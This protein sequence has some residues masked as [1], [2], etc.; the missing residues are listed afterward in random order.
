M[1]LLGKLC[2]APAVSGFEDNAQDIAFAELATCTD[3]IWRDRLGNVISCKRARKPVEVAGR[4]RTPKL[5][6]AAHIDEIGLMVSHIDDGGFIRFKPIG[7]FDP[8]TLVS[9]RVHV[10]GSKA[11]SNTLKGVIA[12]QSG[13]LLTAA[14]RQ[15]IF[16][17]RELYIDTGLP[18]KEVL[19]K[20]H[21]GDVITLA[22]T[23]DN[24]NESVVVGRNFDDRVG[25][26]SM[27]EALKRIEHPP[28]DVYAVSTVQEEVGVRGMPTAA[29][30]IAAD[31]GVAIDG[32][33][34]SDTPYALDHERQCHLGGGTGIYLIDNRTIGNPRL[35]RALMET[36]EQEGIAYQRNIGGGTDASVI[37]RSGLG[38]L[39]TTIGA[40]TRYMHSTVQLCH[41]DDIEATIQ[42]LSAFSYRADKLLPADWR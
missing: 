30:A 36:C 42:L 5:L 22:A 13:W 41:L 17:I 33:L 19:G 21:I 3:D 14:D 8:R 29:A 28:V 9:Q 12:P 35:V 24:L 27:I 7:G 23:F 10:H 2:N 20:V 26:Y 31:I 1:E 39:S 34:A 40:P 6:Y 32:S 4:D 37:Q 11:G 16:P 25:V 15:R 18:A 38:A